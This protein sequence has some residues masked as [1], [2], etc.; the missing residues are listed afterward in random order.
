M[1]VGGGAGEGSNLLDLVSQELIT[2]YLWAEECQ[3][4]PPAIFNQAIYQVI[5]LT[6]HGSPVG[7]CVLALTV[8]GFLEEG[9]L[10]K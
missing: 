4:Q 3:T 5:V 10:I 8:Y 1:F 7:N 6:K 2:L 9:D